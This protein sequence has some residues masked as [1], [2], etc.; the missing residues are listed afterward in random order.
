MKEL[1]K[2]FLDELA[3]IFFAENLLVKALPKLAKAAQ[4]RELKAAFESHLE[5]T[6]EQTERLKNVFQIFGKPAKG[7]K[8][9]AM[10]GLLEEGK[11]IMEEWKGSPALDAALICGAQK[12]EHYEIAAYGCLCTWADLMGNGRALKLLKQTINEEETADTK[13]TEIAESSINAQAAEQSAEPRAGLNGRARPGSK[14]KQLA[15]SF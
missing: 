3:D 6:K 7:K 5:E 11:K 8:C 12:V 13:L 4:S 1:E 9:H 14:R 10:E 2:L 15:T